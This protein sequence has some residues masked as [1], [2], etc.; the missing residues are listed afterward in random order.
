MIIK[1]FILTLI[2]LIFVSLLAEP[3]ARW[4]R[5]PFVAIL[6]VVGFIGSELVVSLG[7]DTGIRASN[8]P[9]LVFY[10][11]LPII[12][13]ESAYSIDQKQLQ[14]SLMPIL[15]LA[16]PIMILATLMIAFLLYFL[17][18]HPTGFP[19][20]TALVAASLLAATD[21]MAVIRHLK[22][23]STSS[24]TIVLLEGESLFND[25]IGVVLFTSFVAIAVSFNGAGFGDFSIDWWEK[26]SIFCWQFFGGLLFGILCG[27]I[28]TFFSYVIKTRILENILLIAIAYGSFMLAEDY[29]KVSGMM[30]VLSAGLIMNKA[31]QKYISTRDKEFIDYWWH[32]IGYFSNS[33]L[34]ILLGVTVTVQ[35]FTDR[36]LAMIIAI[37]AVLVVRSISVFG[38]LP[39]FTSFNKFSLSHKE[40]MI[41]TW[42]GARGAVTAA[43]AL[44][45][46]TQIEGWLTV[47]SMAFGVILFTLFIQAPT[48]PWILKPKPNKNK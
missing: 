1:N 35:M 7:Y 43:L 8:F 27:L 45:L 16:L 2:I 15:V 36:W 17:I 28:G 30:A 37:G 4:L 40:L 42:G 22:A 31:H 48:I 38:L 33:M 44:S 11:F 19:I 46:P 20:Y 12:I 6:I 25:A 13:F 29:V 47:Q 9:V 34:F 10:V 18:G 14:K 21:P 5:L 39:L 24:E 41:L 26:L 3:I 23:M 32:V